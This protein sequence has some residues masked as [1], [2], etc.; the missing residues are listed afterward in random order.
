M[1]TLFAFILAFLPTRSTHHTTHA[2]VVAMARLSGMRENNIGKH[3]R[4][5]R[6]S[7]MERGLIVR[8]HQR[9]YS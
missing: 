4:Q 7:E 9:R 2:T 5:S 3:V 6:G 1:C 8:G